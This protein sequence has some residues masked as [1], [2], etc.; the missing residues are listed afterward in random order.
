M[1]TCPSCG[2]EYSD[3]LNY[4]LDDGS[5]L[6]ARPTSELTGQP[7]EIYRPQTNR[8]ADISTAETIVDDR[9]SLGPA[10]VAKQFQVSA[11]EPSSRMGCVITMGSIAAILVVVAGLGIVGSLYTTRS[12]PDRASVKPPDPTLSN[13]TAGSANVPT[14]TGVTPP[15]KTTAN[16]AAT[17][18]GGIKTISGGVINGKAVSLPKPPYPPAAR[19]VRA[20]GTVTVQ[21]LVDTDGHVI[22]ASA[23]SGH[24]LLKAA[25]ESAARSAVFEPTLLSGRPVRVSGV[26]TYNF[27][28]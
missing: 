6:R 19:A 27:V 26:I 2:N 7:T 22:S 10:P 25:A 24:P 12:S 14:G 3:D 11:V 23:V 8:D 17:P 1:K 5:P 20:S 13:S 9:G 21:V 18:P 16:D 15:S 28:P 4:C